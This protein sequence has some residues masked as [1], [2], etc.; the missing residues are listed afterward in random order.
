MS[1]LLD[2]AIEAVAS[3]LSTAVYQ[4]PTTPRAPAKRRRKRGE[5][6]AGWAR[7]PAPKRPE[8]C[9]GARGHPGF[10]VGTADRI[11]SASFLCCWLFWPLSAVMS[12][13]GR[14]PRS[15]QAQLGRAWPRAW[16]PLGQPSVTSQLL[17]GS[18]NTFCPADGLNQGGRSCSHFIQWVAAWASKNQFGGDTQHR[19]ES[20]HRTGHAPPASGCAPSHC[21]AGPTASSVRF[22]VRR[23]SP[24]HRTHQAALILSVALLGHSMWPAPCSWVSRAVLAPRSVGDRSAGHTHHDLSPA[25]LPEAS[26]RAPFGAAGHQGSGSSP[27]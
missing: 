25:P 4:R 14:P 12:Q 17:R 11:S 22:M 2:E 9:W 13:R 10:S 15:S 7:A 23:A 26:G 6:S 18:A 27:V 5:H 1:P 20:T 16:V 21:A 19:G 8:D 3:G 24:V